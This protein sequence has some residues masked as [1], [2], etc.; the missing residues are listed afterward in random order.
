MKFNK[1]FVALMMGGM[2]VA[3]APKADPA[4]TAEEGAEAATEVAPKEKTAKD[5]IAKKSEK[6]SVAYLIGVNFGSFIKGYNF[7]DDLSYAQIKKG[8]EDFIKAKG[9]F[10]D[11]DFNKQFKIN[12]E[13]MNDVFNKYLEKRHNYTA[14][15]NKE[16]GEKFLAA[17]KGRGGV[18]VTPSGLQ[19]KIIS[20]GSDVKA[21]ADADTVW[22]NYKG[23]LLD[24]TVFDET[25]EGAEPVRMNLNRVIKGWTEGLKLVGEGGEIELYIPSELAYGEGGNQGIEPNSTLIFNVKVSKVGKFVAPAEEEKK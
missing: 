9:D 5:Y 10:R 3:C 18:Q 13:S 22:V 2:M 1:L 8:I 24:G 21:T 20:E 11:P 23:T 16:A 6:D 7:G 25:P 17:N 19:Y 12:P 14:L 15:K 4:A